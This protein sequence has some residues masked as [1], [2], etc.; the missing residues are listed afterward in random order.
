MQQ[1]VF[2]ILTGSVLALATVGFAIVRQTQGFLN[3]AHGQFLALG[4][5][6]GLLLVD[7]FGLPVFLALLL[8]ALIVG[9]LG[10][11]VAWIVFIPIQKS[12][13]LVLFFTSI[14]LAYVIHGV[15]T[16]AWGPV[17]RVYP[18][19]FGP[20]FSVGSVSIT[21]GELAVIF[22]SMVTIAGLQ[23]FLTRSNIGLWIRGVATNPE[24]ATIRG[25]RSRVVTLVA[26][27]LANSLAALAGVMI[28]A[29][30]AVNI[31]LGWQYILIILAAA[32]LGGTQSLNGVI[33]ASLLLG[34]VMDLSSLILPTQYRTTIAF[35]A[36]IVTLMVR[37][38]GLFAPSRRRV[39]A[40]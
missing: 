29:L 17:I 2:G 18:I 5:L 4:A 19:T 12:G 1:I 28:G 36:I 22:V 30:G 24:L 37:P 14:G 11:L 3:I 6:M 23:L 9:V 15:I 27:F 16:L 21:L 34:L 40:T 10:V 20:S 32:V 38:Q 26:W 13:A 35:V 31:D 8:T 39:E 25:V 33:A 7:G